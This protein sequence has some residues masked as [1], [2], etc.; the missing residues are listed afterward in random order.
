MSK[1]VHNIQQ[2]QQ[3][4]REVTTQAL[5]VMALQMEESE[6]QRRDRWTVDS[7]AMVHVVELAIASRF[8]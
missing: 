3:L 2:E 7:G 1:E 4:V 8:V 6:T 5:W